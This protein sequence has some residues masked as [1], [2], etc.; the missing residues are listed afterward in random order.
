MVEAL[1]QKPLCLQ[2][3]LGSLKK[4]EFLC[5]KI[6]KRNMFCFL[7]KSQSH[8]KWHYFWFRRLGTLFGRKSASNCFNLPIVIWGHSSV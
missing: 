7:D 8:S 4:V 1:I 3:N 6:F 5:G 2:N